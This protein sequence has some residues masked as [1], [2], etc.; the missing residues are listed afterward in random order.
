MLKYF[1]NFA[2][3]S[4]RN[5]QNYSLKM[6]LSKGGFDEIKAYSKKDIDNQFYNEYKNIL[7]Q[8]RGAGYWLWKPYFI[9]KKLEELNEGDYLFYSDSGVFFR[10]NVD[11]L[12]EVLE[13]N[14]Q[15]IMGFQLPLIE[16]QWTKKELIHDMDCNKARFTESNQILAS[17][18]LIKK[19]NFSIS[20]F[21]EFLDVSCNEINI[22]D[23]YDN[24][25]KQD[26]D[27][28]EHRH[29]QSIFS[30]L[31]K[32]YSLIPFKDPTQFGKYPG[33]YSSGFEDKLKV[34]KLHRLN[35]GRLFR[36]FDYDEKYENIMFHNR[37]EKPLNSL[38]KFKIKEIMYKLRVYRGLV[39]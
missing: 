15:D 5:Q 38:I 17:Y 10:K 28:I 33:G 23:K 25:V 39:S 26:D 36:Y 35:N 3:H 18:I 14:D 22:T 12:I 13:K 27:F 2:N 11:V 7:E 19:T 29:D 37:I 20:F 9:N 4:F 24:S 21:Q 32:K 30:L 1:I 8:S 6:A 16:S 31:Y 34:N